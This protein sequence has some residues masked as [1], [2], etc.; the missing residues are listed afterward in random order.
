MSMI[1][2]Y[3]FFFLV[4]ENTNWLKTKEALLGVTVAN[5]PYKSAEPEITLYWHMSSM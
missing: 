1:A 2:F 3:F 4:L 5:V